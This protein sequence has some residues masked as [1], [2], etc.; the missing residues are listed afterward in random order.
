[1][2]SRRSFRVDEL[3]KQVGG[4]L[5]GDGSVEIHG[6]ASLADAGP[7]DLSFFAND[8]YLDA[9]ATT[10]AGALVTAKNLPEAKMPQIVL[11]DPFLGINRLV[12]LFHPPDESKPA[13][14]IDS[15]ASVADSARAILIRRGLTVR[16]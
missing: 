16:S 2:R 7:T 9:L 12:D 14:G 3:A 4:S 1:M 10:R 6:V 13:A 15:R 8:K 11:A 5:I